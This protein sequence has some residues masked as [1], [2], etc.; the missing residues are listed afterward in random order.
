[1]FSGS[2]RSQ[3]IHK[4]TTFS[5][6]SGLIT[7]APIMLAAT[8]IMRESFGILDWWTLSSV[9]ILIMTV[10]SYV[11]LYYTRLYFSERFKD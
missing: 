8:Y 2:K 10:V 11:R 4:E 1:M 6:V 9:N 3:R 7:Q 5:I